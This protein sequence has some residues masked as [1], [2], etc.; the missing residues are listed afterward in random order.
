M[1]DNKL[2]AIDYPHKQ[3]SA[4]I[5]RY[6]L[7]GQEGLKPGCWVEGRTVFGDVFI[8]TQNWATY[9]RP[10]FAY[11]EHI[12]IVRVPG[13]LERKHTASIAQGYSKSFTQSVSVNYS[14]SAAINVVNVSSSIE[15][16]YSE[17][18]TWSTDTTRSEEIVFKGPEVY[19]GYQLH[20]VYA[21]CAGS[22]AAQVAHYFRHHKQLLQYGRR[23]DLFYL[24]SVAMNKFHYVTEKESIEPLTWDAVQQQVLANYDPGRND[25]KFDFDLK[26]HQNHYQRY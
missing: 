24:S 21:H 10:V 1:D 17:T 14:V 26:A 4:E 13:Q 5:E 22:A 8:G 7:G 18:E 3:G 23:L 19:Y 16:G 25:G 2:A 20:M 9:S 12:D 15:V 11:L 6:L